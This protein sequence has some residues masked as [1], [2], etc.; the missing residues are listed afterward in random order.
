MRGRPSKYKRKYCKKILEYF[1][2]PANRIVQRKIHYKNG[3]TKTTNTLIA[4]DLPTIEGFC[5]QIGINKST[6]HEWVK[7]ESEFS[8]AYKMAKEMQKDIWLQNSLKGLY[9][10]TFTIFAGKNIFGWKDNRDVDI[11]S[12]NKQIVGFT[13]VA[14]DGNKI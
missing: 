14:P 8:N 7:S 9:N 11:T 2:I 10:P 4:N 5:K 1:D 3:D 6:L 13:M 12:N